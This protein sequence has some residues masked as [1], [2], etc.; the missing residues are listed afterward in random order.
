MLTLRLFVVFTTLIVFTCQDHATVLFPE[1]SSPQDQQ[2]WG[3]L[4][5]KRDVHRQIY[6]SNTRDVC[7][8]SPTIRNKTYMN[9]WGIQQG[10]QGQSSFLVRATRRS[11]NGKKLPPSKPVPTCRRLE[12]NGYRRVKPCGKEIL[13]NILVKIEKLTLVPFKFT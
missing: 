12:R 8:L 6:N 13:A 2:R 9:F 5:R 11:T 7:E 4:C 1:L 3:P 10:A